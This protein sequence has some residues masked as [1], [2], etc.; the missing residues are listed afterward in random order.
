M[1]VFPT[2]GVLA[3]AVIVLPSFSSAQTEQGQDSQA[4][5]VTESIQFPPNDNCT[6]NKPCRTVMGE[7]RRVEET[8]VLKQPNG[9]EIHVKIHPE[10]KV[11]GLHKQGD[12]VAAQLSSRG[13]AHAVV[14]LQDLP[15]PALEAPKKTLDD[16]R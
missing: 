12:K 14:K 6:A 5:H 13:V 16:L 9:S 8:Y 1:K 4:E 3:I 10:T 7:I 11:S 2:L 15:K